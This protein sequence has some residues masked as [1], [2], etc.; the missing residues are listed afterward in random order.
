MDERAAAAA[1]TGSP[2]RV[3]LVSSSYDPYV[4]G[5]EEHVRQVARRLRDD[6]VDVEVWTVDR[7]E[8]LGVREV[9]GVTVR[10]LSTPLPA[11]SV[12]AALRFLL[13]LPSAWRRWADARRRFRPDLVHVHCFGPNGAYAL[14]MHRRF[15]IPLIVTSHGETIADDHAVFAR[16]ALLRTALRRALTAA[17][18]VT[19][20]SQFVI[21]DLRRNH[22]LVGGVVVPNG[23]EP[24]PSATTTGSGLG[25]RY[26]LGVGR[27]GRMKGFDLLIDAFARAE[28]DRSI[29]LVI[30]GDGPERD[31]LRIQVA[32]L[33]LT[34]RI[35]LA[36][37]LDAAAV[38][39]AMSGALAVVVP[40]RVE[41][42]GIVALEAWRSGA[43][44]VM[45]N[46]G[47]AP[48]FMRDGIDAVLVDPEDTAAL[49]RAIE[50]MSADENLR[51]QFA[52]AGR[53]RVGEFTWTRVAHAYEELYA[54]ASDRDR[55]LDRRARRR[56]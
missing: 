40:S 1:A 21:D 47:G 31:R 54:A 42:F 52:A 11:A 13:R 30:A 19:A 43:P 18:R 7:G 32:R 12:G 39:Q 48:D 26:L 49:C 44:L 9:D 29:R 41:A 8:S 2:P 25:G 34:D 22:G 4:G 50:R 3:A 14:A 23:V 35:E 55:G 46:R 27:L 37:R 20:P 15:G 33:G 5:V 51:M 53:E 24:A 45:T 36:G 10:Y 17:A 16:S 56:A 6:G 38:A 28:L